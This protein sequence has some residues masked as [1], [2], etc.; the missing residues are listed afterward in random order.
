MA[1]HDG[2]AV[3]LQ[4]MDGVFDRLLVEVPGPGHPRIGEPDHVPPEA[5]HGRFVRQPGA[6]RR[7]VE[8]GDQ[9]LLRQQVRIATRAGDRLQ[10]L[11]HL[12][13]PHELG[14]LEVLQGKDVAPGKTAHSGHSSVRTATGLDRPRF[15]AADRLSH[16][17]LLTTAGRRPDRAER[18]PR[19]RPASHTVT[20]C[21]SRT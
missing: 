7:L 16:P 19:L 20:S 9:G 21:P 5:M 3:I 4:H 6:G 14:A 2:V 17:P 11:G 8:G 15:G 1:H 13:H 12:E 10:L 18:P